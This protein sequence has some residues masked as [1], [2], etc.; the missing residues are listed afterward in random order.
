VKTNKWFFIVNSTAGRGKTGKKINSLLKF[1]NE[2][3]FNYEIELTKAPLHAVELTEQAISN[4]FKNIVA[5]GGDGTVNEVVNGIMKSGN[6]EKINFGIIPEGGGNDFAHHFHLSHKIRKAVKIL[7]KQKTVKV[8]VGKIEDFFFINAFGIG[9]DA[10]VARYSRR[11][12]LLNGLLRYLPAVLKSL[13]FLKT[14]PLEISLKNT[15]LKSEYLLITIGNS[16]F[17]GSGFQLTPNAV[18]DDGLFDVCLIEKVN[19]RRI[20]KLLPSALKGKHLA[21][22]EVTVFRSNIIEIKS[23]RKLP[24]Y[25]DGELPNLKNENYLKIELIPKKINLIC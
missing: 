9:F 17:C 5:V 25:F 8:D 24:V 23:D 18:A 13:V 2:Q 6:P 15:K 4:G 14:Y 22:P 20:L 19:R 7:K 10:E 21:E 3:N 16:R 12:F 1:L 11:I